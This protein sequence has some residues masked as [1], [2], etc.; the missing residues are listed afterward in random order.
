MEN[1]EGLLAIIPEEAE[2]VR[3]IFE[4]HL[5]GYSMGMIQNTLL[6]RRIPSPAGRDTWSKK[7]I[8]EVLENEKYCGHV[9]LMKT[10]RV[11]E[12]DFKRTKNRGEREKY[13]LLNHHP[14]II[15]EE[16]FEHVQNEKKR[17]SNLEETDAGYQR[18]K[19]HYS[20]KRDM[21]GMTGG[22][23]SRNDPGVEHGQD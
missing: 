10:I 19:T 13:Q 17:R 15:S 9:I 2:A 16:M 22:E 8:S 18:K 11:E 5:Q 20:A 4:L 7:T 12:T 14:A 6:E 23:D 21:G 1:P 3:L